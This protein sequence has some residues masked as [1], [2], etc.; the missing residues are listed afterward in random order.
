[1]KKLLR[2]RNI[3]IWL[4]LGYAMTFLVF[5][6]RAQADLI[7]KA[8]K[9][10]V[11][12]S[13][14]NHAA[15]ML[16]KM[17]DECGD[18]D[19]EAYIK[20]FLTELCQDDFVITAEELY[21]VHKQGLNHIKSADICISDNMPRYPLHKG[22]YPTK[23][24]LE[25]GDGYAVVAYSRKSDVYSKDGI[26]YID[27]NGEAFQVTGYLDKNADWLIESGLLLF[28]GCNSD[29]AWGFLAGY[30]ED[31]Y[32]IIRIESDDT[33]NLSDNYEKYN[34]RAMEL[35]KGSFYVE[36]IHD[37]MYWQIEDVHEEYSRVPTDT[38]KTYAKYIFAFLV[39][40]LCFMVEFW[41]KQRKSEFATMRKHGF[42]VCN[43]IG[44]IY[45][46]LLIFAA[47]GTVLGGIVN[48]ALSAWFDGYI[49]F[50]WERT[51]Y[52]FV[53]LVVYIVLV[54]ALTSAFSVIGI[55][56][57]DMRKKSVSGLNGGK[58]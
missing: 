7:M 28:C 31:G 21:L 49:A 55:I 35:S 9:E 20:A 22:A 14:F 17:T 32:L 26:E 6:F 57:K 13:E 10:A 11:E 53:I 44:R 24:Q 56:I 16:I 38:A 34:E 51:Y 5:N 54:V 45:G 52:C 15:G 3:G 58:K 33:G 40:M 19:V 23:Q 42:S 1:M 18:V 50:D 39:V 2:Y 48:L 4:I 30:L 43:I 47:I 46:E 12:A 8:E 36:Y 29:G 37:V 27:F 41:M 25:T